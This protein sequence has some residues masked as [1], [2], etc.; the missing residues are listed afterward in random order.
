[1]NTPA[2]RISTGVPLLDSL[3]HGGL[4]RGSVSVVSGPPGSGKT[5]LAQ[6]LSFA[7][8][9]P[10]AKVLSFNTLSEP[11]AKTLRYLQSFAF[12]DAGQLE[13]SIAFVDLGSI[14]RSDGLAEA[15]SLMMRHLKAVQPS[16][17]IVDSFKVFD[18]LATT[19]EQQRKFGY[20]MAV[21][22]MAWET[23]A[24]LLGEYGPRDYETNP[25]FSIVDGL[26]LLSQREHLGENQRFLR[27][28]KMR[29]TDHS[30]EEV[31]FRI[32]SHGIQLFA[33]RAAPRPKTPKTPKTPTST[34]E[35]A[36]RLARV[37]THIPKLD[38][39]LGSGIQP[40]SSVLVSGASGT[41]KTL[42]SL[43]FL[44]RGA[45]AG[46]KGIYFSF[47]ESEDRLR[48]EAR[49]LG[50]ELDGLLASGMLRFV[51]V[52]QPDIQVE[53]DLVRI[54]E[55]VAAAGARRVVVDS[56]SVFLHKI[57]DPQL[58]REKAFHLATIV[59]AHDAVGFFV[60]DVPYGSHQ[61]S[62]FG[63]E[64]TVV[65]GVILL[66]AVEEGMARE[67]YIEIYKLRNTDHLLGRH[68]M[69]LGKTGVTIFPRY[70]R[71]SLDATPAPLE[72]E[73]LGSGVPGFDELLGGGLL[74]RSVTLLS[75]S[76]GAGKTTAAL[77]FLLEGARLG[78]RGLYVTLEE[79]P[80]QLLA[81]ADALELP[82]RE[83]AASGLIE[84]LHISREQV[85][86]VQLL[87]L[88]ADRLRN[89]DAS[90]VVI[91]ALT[92]MSAPSFGDAELLRLLYR[93]ML[94]FKS[95]GVTTILTLESQHLYFSDVTSEHRLSPVAD[96][97][98]LL[99][100]RR[101]ET[102]LLPELSVVKTRGSAHERRSRA[103]TI[104]KG[105]MTVTADATTP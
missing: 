101:D 79:G 52:A 27:V 37:R 39:L 71:D 62:R 86:A 58:S 94:R 60:V 46:E 74:R 96:N 95:L 28:S 10:D 56:L 17:V 76:A 66:S 92:Q 64:E 38:E 33:S 93:L 19:P 2:P 41:G 1:M 102:G 80:Q 25:L 4:P 105:G 40:G 51:V 23:T 72:V 73:R 42:L 35:D 12:F 30:R 83:A 15:S 3:L 18:D 20:E 75:G 11:T 31:P 47:E 16:I 87:S 91:D 65:D 6:Q 61:L 34:P 78:Q 13:D 98:V 44:Y 36:Q 14:L 90:R 48:R 84:I 49:A 99:R 100:Y 22:L 81:S 32:S 85:G 24:L 45:L 70:S 43:E 21:N 57:N 29:G 50:W 104:G 53:A 63:V 68:S 5:I 54:E 97:L 77:Q 67:R 82:L 59:Q 89:L 55:H 8:A 103:V 9:R 69:V 88:L 26:L 7:N